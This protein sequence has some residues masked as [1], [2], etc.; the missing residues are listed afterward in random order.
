MYILKTNLGNK[1]YNKIIKTN[2]NNEEILNLYDC[3]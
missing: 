3:I 2:D 1:I